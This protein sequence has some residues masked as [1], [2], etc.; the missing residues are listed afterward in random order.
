[1]APD[2]PAT[3]GW[4][5]NAPVEEWRAY[6]RA[7]YASNPGQCPL[8]VNVD[9]IYSFNQGSMSFIEQ[10][11]R[12]LPEA[13]ARQALDAMDR[14]AL[15]DAFDL[16]RNVVNLKKV[17]LHSWHTSEPLEKE[18]RRMSTFWRGDMSWDNGFLDA[19]RYREVCVAHLR[20]KGAA[21]AVFDGRVM[22]KAIC[23]VPRHPE[24]PRPAKLSGLPRTMTTHSWLDQALD[25]L[26]E[27]DKEI[28]AEG[29]DSPGAD[30]GADSP[31][32]SAQGV[33]RR[34]TG[35]AAAKNAAGE[36]S[37]VRRQLDAFLA[38]A[39]SSN[40]H[41]GPLRDWPRHILQYVELVLVARGGAKALSVRAETE[42]YARKLRET[43]ARF[44]EALR[45]L[46]ERVRSVEDVLRDECGVALGDV[47]SCPRRFVSRDD[48]GERAVDALRVAMRRDKTLNLLEGCAPATAELSRWVDEICA[49]PSIRL[50][51]A[52]DAGTNMAADFVP[53]GFALGALIGA[54]AKEVTARWGPELRLHVES[55]SGPNGEWPPTEP[56]TYVT[57]KVKCSACG[58]SFGTLWISAGVA[59]SDARRTCGRE[60]S[61]P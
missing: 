39:T 10:D 6:V 45:A 35:S 16:R 60:W 23:C 1:M 17:L 51:V 29:A 14:V 21:H 32:P 9:N 31:P 11:L 3:E 19:A 12:V 56:L 42:R 28:L 48:V 54:N 44:D 40:A 18:L 15:R 20:C 55:A 36:P 52:G 26:A 7:A 58:G 33:G 22:T 30:E 13:M 37:D 27:M 46:R 53:P 59:A 8:D 4:T 57:G 61:A 5:R 43:S 49:E 41:S 2:A 25:T 34:A 47:G 38:D 24:L 50:F